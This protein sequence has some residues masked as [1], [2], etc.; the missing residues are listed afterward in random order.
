MLLICLLCYLLPPSEALRLSTTA[1]S[2]DTKARIENAGSVSEAYNLYLAAYNDVED[3]ALR[4]NPI[5]AAIRQR[6]F[7]KNYNMIKDHN[8]HNSGYKMGVNSFTMMTKDERSMFLGANVNS[9]TV[10][11]HG[12]RMAAQGLSSVGSPAART[13]RPYVTAVKNQGESF[14]NCVALATEISQAYFFKTFQVDVV[15]VGLLQPRYLWNSYIGLPLETRNNLPNS[16]IL[17]VLTKKRLEEMAAM[18]ANLLLFGS[19]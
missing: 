18:G 6:A 10:T 15:A 19:K 9:S 17:I 2:A 1:K 13:W 14:S 7:V 12:T 8:K 3:P 11:A 4:A 16:S 5:Q